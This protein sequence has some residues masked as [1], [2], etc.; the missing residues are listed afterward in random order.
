MFVFRLTPFVCA[1]EV[2]HL[3]LGLAVGGWFLCP[4]P[5]PDCCDWHLIVAANAAPCTHRSAERLETCTQASTAETV[6]LPGW[7]IPYPHA[8]VEGQLLHIGELQE[9]GSLTLTTN[10]STKVVFDFY[11]LAYAEKVNGT[12]F[13]RTFIAY[14]PGYGELWLTGA[15]NEQIRLAIRS[16]ALRTSSALPPRTTIEVAYKRGMA[17]TSSYLEPMNEVAALTDVDFQPM[18][19]ECEVNGGDNFFTPRPYLKAIHFTHRR[20]LANVTLD[21]QI[22]MKRADGVSQ[23][24]LIDDWRLPPWVVLYPAAAVIAAASDM[25]KHS[26]LFVL[27]TTHPQEQVYR[28]YNE[29]LRE[30]YLQFGFQ[31][32]SWSEGEE[33]STTDWARDNSSLASVITLQAKLPQTVVLLRYQGDTAR[34]HPVKDHR[35]PHRR[36]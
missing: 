35:R 20:S 34:M 31:R 2:R 32:V 15:S 1:C 36:H 19:F 25:R 16:S 12:Q 22:L 29:H 10:D 26:G 11:Q 5:L 24:S 33:F 13:T 28:F 27:S 7:V 18:R 6:K 14:A 17:W 9:S 8:T 23:P 3:L 30:S 4:V 21:F